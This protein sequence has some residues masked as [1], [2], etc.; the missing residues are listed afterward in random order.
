[1][2]YLFVLPMYNICY[3]V[4]TDYVAISIIKVFQNLITKIITKNYNNFTAVL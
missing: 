4:P 3:Q 2:Q 1:M